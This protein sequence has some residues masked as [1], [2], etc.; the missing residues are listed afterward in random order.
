MVLPDCTECPDFF[1]LAVHGGV[2]GDPENARW[3]FWGANGTY[4]LGGFDGE[5]FAPDGAAQRYDWDGSSYAA[6]TWSD[7]PDG[8][9]IQIAWLRVDPP[10]MPFSQQMTFPCELSLRSTP[11]GV[12]LCSWP[13]PEIEALYSESFR[14]QGLDL[15][16][17]DNPLAGLHGD[18][19]DVWVEFEAGS[20][21]VKLSL[22]L[23]GIEVA[24]SA[25]AGELT[26][27]GRAAPLPPVEG[28]ARLRVLL[29]RTSIE[30]YGNGGLVAL[31]LAVIPVAE[32]QS[33][34]LTST[35]GTTRIVDLQ[36][37]TLRSIWE[38]VRRE[39]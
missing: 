16:E 7:L 22:T 13:A 8:R 24:Y 15:H 9:R 18:L 36:V 20:P 21:D 30:V 11:D 17:G 14:G 12:R 26:C 34:A 4:L 3:V 32:N 37:H 2:D 29:D 39:K 35:G 1:P 6:Q 38:G 19:L 27:Q 23:R 33:H 28:R 25:A 31:P 10:G 5:T